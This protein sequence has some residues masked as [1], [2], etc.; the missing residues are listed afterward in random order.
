MLSSPA[1]HLPPF[2]Y[3]SY[4]C[5]QCCRSGS[6]KFFSGSG[7][8]S[9]SYCHEHNKITWKRELNKEYLLCGFC[10]GPTDK[11]NEVKMYKKVL[12]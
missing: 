10:V 7:S 12:F 6:V 1:W 9:I 5:V 2:I 3:L 11:E 4:I 8:G